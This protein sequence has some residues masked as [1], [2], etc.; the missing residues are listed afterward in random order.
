[1]TLIRGVLVLRD[2]LAVQN[3]Q[4][5]TLGA[6]MLLVLAFDDRAT[7][8]EIVSTAEAETSPPVPT[9]GMTGSEE[10]AAVADPV[11]GEWAAGLLGVRCER[12]N[13]EV[14]WFRIS[15]RA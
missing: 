3:R 15:R 7:L 12:S 6:W 10:W 2:W 13:Q 4:G 8:L 11:S 5:C 1:M 9:Q 14:R